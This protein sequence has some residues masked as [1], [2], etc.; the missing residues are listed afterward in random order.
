MP[1]VLRQ[2]TAFIVILDGKC[3]YSLLPNSQTYPSTS[4]PTGPSASALIP[5]QPYSNAY[6]HTVNVNKPQNVW[7]ITTLCTHVSDDLDRV[8]IKLSTCAPTAV[9][10]ADIS[11]I[12][13]GKESLQPP[14]I[15][16][17]SWS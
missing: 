1:T 4:N 7:H 12:Q 3:L 13:H 9:K 14:S 10:V 2:P 17:C 15:Q 11:E 6:I 8:P 5:L 16:A